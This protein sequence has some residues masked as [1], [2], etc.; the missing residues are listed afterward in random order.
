MLDGSPPVINAPTLPPMKLTTI[1]IKKTMAI[2]IIKFK[3]QPKTFLLAII[4]V[5]YPFSALKMPT[6][7]AFSPV[8][9]VALYQILP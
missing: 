2:I 8:H 3:E 9:E 5:L 6:W 4:P 7:K 1:K